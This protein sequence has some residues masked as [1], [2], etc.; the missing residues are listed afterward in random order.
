MGGA[1]RSLV[2][3][4]SEID[5]SK[6]EVDLLLIK[7]EGSLIEQLP[8]EV[9]LLNTPYELKAVYSNTIEKVQGIKYFIRRGLSIVYSNMINKIHSCEVT[10]IRWNYFYSKLIPQFDK[11][12]DIAISYL[13]GPSMYYVA[14]K[15]EAKKKIVFIHSDYTAS[16]GTI[17]KASDLPYFRKY[18]LI[19]TISAR[20]RDSLIKEFP[21]MEA[22]FVIVPN[23]TS[24]RLIKMRSNQ[25][26]P[27][28]YQG[29]R[30]IVCS[31]G[32][33]SNEKGFDIAIQAASILKASN[34][35][36]SWFIIGEGDQHKKLQEMITKKHLANCFFLLGIRD[37]PYP[38][39]KNANILAQ[40]SRYEGKSIVLDEAKILAKPIVA[41]SY[42]TVRDQLTDEEGM[43]VEMTPQGIAEGIQKMLGNE[44][45]M[46][47]YS[48]Y[49]QR[50]DYGNTDEIKKFYDILK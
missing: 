49:L 43:I 32:R 39:I 42:T 41:T 48:N 46:N 35:L 16:G 40:T 22:K 3:L 11:K 25:F 26:V 18:D 47:N 20:C 44:N 14:D 10:A 2:N 5:Y 21:D 6:Y 1:E 8:K 30:N 12:Y 45:L 23:M 17:G 4:L 15:V 7:K 38:Y 28:E 13:I 37:N 33:L 27:E 19:P 9:N 29:K 24:T 36:F 31:I 50:R 34:I